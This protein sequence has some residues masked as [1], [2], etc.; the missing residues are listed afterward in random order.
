MQSR[1]AAERIK[2]KKPLLQAGLA[3]LLRHGLGTYFNRHL[4][5]FAV[6]LLFFRRFQ[7]SESRFLHMEM[8]VDGLEIIC[9]NLE[10]SNT[11]SKIVSKTFFTST[12]FHFFSSI[13]SSENFDED[14]LP[15]RCGLFQKSH[16]SSVGRCVDFKNLNSQLA[17]PGVLHLRPL[18]GFGFVILGDTRVG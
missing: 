12:Q 4:L 8:P 2:P 13:L 6:M 1:T 3:S 17:A 14:D 7:D 11:Y 5:F 16:R 10:G 15:L 18:L 9:Q